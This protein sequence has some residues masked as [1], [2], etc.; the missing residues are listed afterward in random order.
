MLQTNDNPWLGLASYQESDAKLF[1]GRDEEISL[2]CDI[3]EDNYCTI[4][5]GKSG[6]GKTS[7]INA[8]L[9]PALSNQNYLPITLKL[10]HNSDYNYA[11]QI[12]EQTLELLD[13]HQCS[14]E[15]VGNIDVALSE[16]S[17]LWLFFH[18]NIFW[19]STQHRIIPVIF[20]DQFEEIFTI[21]ENKSDTR[22]FFSMLNE[23]FQP[24]PPDELINILEKTGKRLRFEE[25]TN[26]RLILSMREDFLARLED[27]SRNIPILRKNRVGIAPMSGNQALE[28]ILKPNPDIVNRTAALHCCKRTDPVQALRKGL[29]K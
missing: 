9:K 28:V 14:I 4:L 15:K 26:F 1:F 8:G 7:L 19:T 17:K 20:L 29:R 16:S 10:Q 6:M 25:E 21:C 18:S 24:L 23:L 27:Y 11:D 3:I 2:L 5:Y 22:D 12:I 13:T